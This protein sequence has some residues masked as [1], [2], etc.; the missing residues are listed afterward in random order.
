MTWRFT[1]PKPSAPRASKETEEMA[2]ALRWKEH[3]DRAAGD[4]LAR[5]NLRHVVA[6]AMKYRRY[7]VPVSELIAEGNFGVVHALG[8][9]EP[10]RGIRFVTYA[11]HWVRAYI[12]GPRDQVVEHGR[13]R[14][15]PAAFALVLSAASR[16]RARRQLDGRRR[17]R[18]SH[19]RRA[20]RRHAGRATQD[21]ASA[22]SARRLARREGDRRLAGQ[23]GRSAAGTGR[24]G[25]QLVRAS[26]RRQHADAPSPAPCR[27]STRA[28]ATSPS[29]A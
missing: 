6:V 27:S 14:L 10:E 28:N 15:G 5:A 16:A 7:G 25:A 17:S 20:R 1:S 9:F 12:L 13:R 11:A 21:G 23:A 18:R 4:A 29:T 8:K 19:G 26:G 22:R 2:L 24:S 3:R